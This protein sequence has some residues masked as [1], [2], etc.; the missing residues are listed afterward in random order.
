VGVAVL[1]DVRL[2]EGVGVGE[3][4]LLNG[5]LVVVAEEEEQ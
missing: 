2:E 1:L 4:A 3:V 5:L